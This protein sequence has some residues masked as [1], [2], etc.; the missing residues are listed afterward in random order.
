MK[1]INAFANIFGPIGYAHHARKFFLALNKLMPVCLVPKYGQL[2]PEASEET[3]SDMLQRLFEIDLSGVSINLDY[4]EEMLHFAGSTRIGYTVF[5]TN[6]LSD[7]ALNQ[8]RQLNQIWVPTHWAKSILLANG[9]S[10]EKLKVIP[11]GVDCAVFGQHVE[12]YPEIQA[13]EGYRFLSVGKW[14]ERKGIRELLSAFDKAF[15]SLDR[16]FLFLYYPNHVRAL[17]DMSVIDEVNKMGLKNRSKVIVIESEITTEEEMARL[18]ASCDSYVSASKA[19]GWGLP[20]TEAMAS[21]LAVL[22]PFYSGPTEYLTESNSIPLPVEKMDDVYCPV[23]FPNKGEY[24]QW[25]HIDVEALSKKMRWIFE[26]QIQAKELGLQAMKDM[27]T[28]WTW[29]MAANKAAK[30]LETF[31]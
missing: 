6:K 5:E 31:I 25:A 7:M 29:D 12:P 10:E 17:K 13:L 4:P 27:Q 22:A 30:V 1:T 18:Y 19:E 2:P 8:L 26:N 11:E 16:V 15:S 20:I 14:E 23:F 9:L 24:G 3:F 21:G 28:K